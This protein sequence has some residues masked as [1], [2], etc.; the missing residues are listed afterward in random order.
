TGDFQLQEVSFKRAPPYA[1]L[2]YQRQPEGAVDR[3]QLSFAM[4]RSGCERPRMSVTHRFDKFEF[5]TRRAASLGLEYCWFDMCCIDDSSAAR[6]DEAACDEFT[7][8]Q[9]ATECF[10]HLADVPSSR[11]GGQWEA[12]FRRSSYFRSLE[13]LQVVLAASAVE[14]FSAEGH[15]LGNKKTLETLLHETM[16]VPRQALRGAEMCT[17]SVDERMGWAVSKTAGPN[18]EDQAYA[19]QGLLG[20]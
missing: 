3:S 18:E 15:L 19:M 20:V 4:M 10:V 12:E 13:S 5:Y 2:S 17:F 9:S 16:G 14:F 1:V 11:A 6:I 8:L 7:R